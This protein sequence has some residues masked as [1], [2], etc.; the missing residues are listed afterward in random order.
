MMTGVFDMTYREIS[1]AVMTLVML[2]VYG[3]YSVDLVATWRV[4]P[5]EEIAYEGRLFTMV[6]ILVALLVIAHIVLAIANPKTASEEGDERDRLIELKGEAR[7]GLIVGMSAIAAM[8]LA[9]GQFDTFYIAHMLLAG[10]VL[11]EIF[12]GVLVLIS[13][14]LGG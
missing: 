7:S 8:L 9:V 13:Y 4:V 5:V 12:K 14:R 6:G 3:W 1:A 2:L 10:L 11:S